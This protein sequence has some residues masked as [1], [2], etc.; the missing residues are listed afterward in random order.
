MAPFTLEELKA[1]MERQFLP[2]MGWHN[3]GEWHIDHIVPKA[4]FKYTSPDC[5]DFASCWALSNLRPLWAQAN[6]SKGTQA[7]HLI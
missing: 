6:I 2:R 4:E 3:M 5:D 1:H 7:T